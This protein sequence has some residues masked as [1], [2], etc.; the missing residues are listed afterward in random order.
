MKNKIVK[1]LVGMVLFLVVLGIVYLVHLNFFKIDVVFYSAILD[2]VISTIITFMILYKL[3][4]FNLFNN[5][6]KMQMGIMY[7]LLGYMFAI[8]IPTVL[9]R[10][11]SFYLLEKIQQR[12]GGIKQSGFEDVFTKEYMVEHRL[13]DVRL[14]E[15]LSSGTIEI[16]N[17]CVKLTAKGN[18]LASF[19]R[20]FRKHFLPKERL[21]MGKYTDDLT[22]P[23]GHGAVDTNKT[24][25]YICK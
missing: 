19:S 23:F 12:G 20:Y 5:F 4:F 16:I 7:M 10:S 24:F 11:L 22:D 6:E 15:Q 14:T 9:D 13:V 3:E 8:S 25:D 21:L 1:S 2:G 18:R 17:G